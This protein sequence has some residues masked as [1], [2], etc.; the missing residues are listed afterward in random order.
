MRQET[1]LPPEWRCLEGKVHY[2]VRHSPKEYSCS[3]PKC[4][5][6]VHADGDFPDRC[7]LF[8]DAHPTLFCRRCG[9][10]SF[11]DAFGDSG[12]EKPTPAELEHWRVQRVQAE[13]DRKHSAERALANLKDSRVWEQYHR[14]LNNDGRKY[15]RERGIP[16]SLQNY[17]KLGWIDEYLLSFKD[18][19]YLTP[20]A[21]I[22]LFSAGWQPLNIKHRLLYPPEGA[23]KYRYELYGQPQPLFLSNPDIPLDGL[24]L[25]IEGEIKA[26][27]AW[28]TLANRETR[29]VGIPGCS[30]SQDV[31]SQLM[32]AER[33]VLVL[34]PGAE[35]AA[36]KLALTLGIKRCRVLIP[37][38]KIDDAIL[39]IKPSKQELGR[40]LNMALPLE[41]M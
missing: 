39:A 31:I 38:M 17:W 34:D 26:M 27:V 13:T 6:E 30:P 40:M 12:F 16:D 36:R 20:S 29:V 3:C 5:G 25:V 4:G 28:L 33:I 1:P 14:Q 32:Q 19:T 11:P 35:E 23:G 22:P 9:L 21:T 37:P 10:V 24:V 41:A 15:W 2:V 7:R 8:V 18:E